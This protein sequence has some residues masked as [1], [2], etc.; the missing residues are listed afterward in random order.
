VAGIE[1]LETPL[2]LGRSAGIDVM[3]TRV[4]DLL[5]LPTG[6]GFSFG[7]PAALGWLGLVLGM[8]GIGLYLHFTRRASTYVVVSGKGYRPRSIRLGGWK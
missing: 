5:H 1:S 7:P 2:A 6:I 4:F 3:A 8:L